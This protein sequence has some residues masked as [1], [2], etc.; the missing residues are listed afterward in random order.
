MPP[1]ITFEVKPKTISRSKNRCKSSWGQSRCARD[2]PCGALHH[3]FLIEIE[4]MAMDRN[5]YP[6]SEIYEAICLID[7]IG[8]EE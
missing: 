4:A 5:I 3:G 7:S 8:S 1:S 6:L 2:N